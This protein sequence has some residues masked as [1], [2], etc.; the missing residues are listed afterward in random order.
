[1]VRHNRNPESPYF[2]KLD[3][4][5]ESYKAKH[6]N[7]NREWRYNFDSGEMRPYEDLLDRRE[8]S[9]QDEMSA[10]KGTID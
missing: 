9:K 7:V 5:I 4:N 3:E 8:N 2:Q 6:Y 1:M 10:I